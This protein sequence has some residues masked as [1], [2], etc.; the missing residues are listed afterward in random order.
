MIKSNYTLTVGTATM[1]FDFEDFSESSSCGVDQQDL[2]KIY[3]DERYKILHELKHAKFNLKNGIVNSE[4]H[5]RPYDEVLIDAQE[6]IPD[7]FE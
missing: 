2:A 6:K 1:T 5:V 4:F 3:G 7:L